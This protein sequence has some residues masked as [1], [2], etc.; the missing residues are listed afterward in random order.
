MKD[1]YKRSA[2]NSSDDHIRS[3]SQDSEPR[4]S[5]A[6]NPSTQLE[7]V[8]VCE[9]YKKVVKFCSVRPC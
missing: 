4:V 7:S 3:D 2:C 9:E 1:K 8:K 5:Q 6:T